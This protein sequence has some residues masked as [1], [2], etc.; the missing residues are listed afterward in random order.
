[1][2][3]RTFFSACEIAQAPPIIVWA[4][5]Y[6]AGRVVYRRRSANSAR[7][8]SLKKIIFSGEKSR[9]FLIFRT[10]F[11]VCE[12]AR[13]SLNF[14]C[15]GC[16]LP[17]GVV[18]VC[19]SLESAR[20][21]TLKIHKFSAQIG[22]APASTKFGDFCR[23]FAEFMGRARQPRARLNRFTKTTNVKYSRRLRG[24]MV[25]AADFETGRPRRAGSNPEDGDRRARLPRDRTRERGE[26]RGGEERREGRGEARRGEERRGEERRGERGLREERR[27]ERRRRASKPRGEAAMPLFKIRF[28][29]FFLRTRRSGFGSAR[30]QIAARG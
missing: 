26:A 16:R 10:F 25:K 23:N 3:F 11:G 13:A 17:L 27:G 9:K 6:E 29:F 8:R 30:Q 20:F 22:S 1:M 2:K 7:S 19:R 24:L 5:C 28:A 4:G 21:G 15:A 14:F 12:I 18:R